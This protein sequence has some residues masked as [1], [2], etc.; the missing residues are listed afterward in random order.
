ML[1]S[2][3]KLDEAPGLVCVLCE[4]FCH[5]TYSSL[6]AECSILFF[7]DTLRNCVVQCPCFSLFIIAGRWSGIVARPRC[8]I[9]FSWMCWYTGS[10]KLVP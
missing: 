4:G 10:D 9:Q 1:I 3:Q 5:A 2:H 7:G 8:A 6:V